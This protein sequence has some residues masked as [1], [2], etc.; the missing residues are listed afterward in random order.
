MSEPVLGEV[1]AAL[2]PAARPLVD[3]VLAVARAEKVEVFLVGG[4][5]RDHL[6]GL[7]VRDVDLLVVPRED[8]AAA[9]LAERAAP[10]DVPVVSHGR[11]GTVR[12]GRGD[13]QLDL[14]T[15]RSETYAH[16]GALPTVAAGTLETDLL[17][18]DFTVNSLALPLSPAARRRHPGLVDAHGGLDDL[19]AKVLRVH[20]AASFRDDPTRALRAARLGPRLGFALT[21]GSRSALRDALRAGAFGNVSGDRLRR[22]IEKTFLDARLDLDPAEALRRLATWHVLAALEPGLEL[23][24]AAVTPL[25][26]LGRALGAPPFPLR[27][28]PVL[29]G[30]LVWLAPLGRGLRRRAAQRFGIRGEALGRLADFP[31]ARD[32]WLRG[33]SKARGRGAIDALLGALPDEEL[34]ALHASAPPGVA[35][36]IA[37]WADQDRRKRLPVDGRDLVEIGLSGPAV[38]RALARVRT[39]F[40][41]GEVRDRDEAL[42]LARELARRSVA[43]QPRKA[44]SRKEPSET[45]RKTGKRGTTQAGPR[46][47]GKRATRKK[48]KGATGKKQGAARKSKGPATS[49]K[50]KSPRKPKGPA[51]PREARDGPASGGGSPRRKA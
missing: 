35:R 21:R 32:R 48:K 14:A 23:P 31:V 45:A 27:G 11:F 6:L 50:T 51:S 1:M 10:D 39:A 13:A 29:A 28:R 22:E 43:R 5:V 42:A 44:A 49:R 19:H 36:R 3:A 38:G 9:W 47:T 18:R 40:L 33:L 17:R 25:R 24:R 4:P 20:H 41:D 8:R 7:P 15:V 30:L 16:P 2:P 34:L 26:R 12:M 37:R 46:K